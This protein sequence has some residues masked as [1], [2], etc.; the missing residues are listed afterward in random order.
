MSRLYG[1]LSAIIIFLLWL[2]ILMICFIIGV[3]FNSER[4]LRVMRG[5]VNPNMHKKR[6]RKQTIHNESC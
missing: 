5:S 2:Y 6:K 3:I 1:A 4:V